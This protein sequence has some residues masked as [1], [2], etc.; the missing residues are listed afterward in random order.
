[1]TLNAAH[2]RGQAVEPLGLPRETVEKSLDAIATVVNRENPD[3]LALQEIDGPSFVSGG[4]DHFERIKQAAKFPYEQRGF[5]FDEGLGSVRFC[6]G[7]GILSKVDLLEKHS[8]RFVENDI[9]F[10]GFVAAQFDFQDRRLL[11]V[12]VHMN[13]QS[14]EKRSKQAQELIDY[15][16]SEK[17]PSIICGDLN[18]Q[19]PNEKDSVRAICDGLK[20][21][22]YQ[23]DS[24][25]LQTF[26]APKS[27]KR[28]DWI[29]VSPELE[30]ISCRVLPDF[31]S[32]HFGVIAEVRW[33][34]S[35]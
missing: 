17:R 22:A 4:F 8:K 24:D 28:L 35:K 25:S 6:Y 13:S 23:P 32:D 20:L 33:K 19:W 27:T 10:K 9:N 5:H 1:M 3:L 15:V 12:S 29:L 2:G 14:A 30:I 11:V 31:V 18:S 21:S 7:T 26:P 16:S 34:P